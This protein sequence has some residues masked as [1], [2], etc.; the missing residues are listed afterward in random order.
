[1]QLIEP[2]VPLIIILRSPPTA[3]HL[4]MS[5]HDSTVDT[6]C[7]PLRKEKRV[8]VVT[9]LLLSLFGFGFMFAHLRPRSTSHSYLSN[10]VDGRAN[11]ALQAPQV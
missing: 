4:T 3:A 8:A 5:A 11:D 1:V 10:I 7:L 9:F 2:F 6:A